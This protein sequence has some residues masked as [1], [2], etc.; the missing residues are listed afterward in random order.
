MEFEKVEDVKL[1]KDMGIE[2]LVEIYKKI[3]G[4][5]PAHLYRAIEIIKEM[6]KKCDTRFLSFTGNIVAT[7]VRGILA[8]LIEEKV[9]NVIITTCGAIDHDIA[10]SFGGTY[11]K[12]F[13]EVNDV[14]LH[15]RN[16]HR[17]GNIFIPIDSYGPLIEN[18]V[19]KV[20]DEL[21]TQNPGKVWSIREILHEI[22]KRI[23]DEYSILRAAAITNTPIYVPGFLDGAFGT[24][25]LMYNQFNKFDIDVFADEKELANIVFKSRCMGALIIGGGISKHHTLWWAQ[26]REGLEYVIYITTAVEWDGSLS[27]AHPR[28]AITWGKVKEE[29]K[30]VVV[31]SDA[32]LVLPIIVYAILYT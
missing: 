5:M 15:R 6:K 24:A 32:T 20:L 11:V 30:H 22:G 16:I 13:F 27:G 10:K 9:F 26:F 2:D 31:Y 14:E 3:H 19:R 29:S 21:R 8:Q 17:L 18:V 12:G 1:R 28:E 25:L 23:N 4:F 7:G